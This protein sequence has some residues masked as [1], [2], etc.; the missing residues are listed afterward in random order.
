[1][2]KKSK[3]R[4]KHIPKRTCVGCREVLPKRSLIRVVKSPEGIRVDP[5]GKAHGRGAYL[6]DERSCWVR[7]IKGGLAHAFKTTLTDQEKHDLLTYMEDNI[8]DESDAQD[9]AEG[10]SG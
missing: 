6:H 4:V 8:P 1:M 2:V 10:I 9:K 5:T 7:G 3:R